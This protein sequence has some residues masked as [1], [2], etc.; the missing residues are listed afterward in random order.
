MDNIAQIALQTLV[1][2]LCLGTSI[3]QARSMGA[4][5]ALACGRPEAQLKLFQGPVNVECGAAVL[6]FSAGPEE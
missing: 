2:F 6:P 3:C 5:L 4:G 1:C